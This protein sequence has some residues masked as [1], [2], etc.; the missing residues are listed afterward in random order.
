M[1]FV[2]SLWIAWALQIEWI[3]LLQALQIEPRPNDVRRSN[4]E[5]SESSLLSAGFFRQSVSIK[6]GPARIQDRL[7]CA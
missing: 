2:F 3:G 1:G 4:Q 7:G 5:G 6:V